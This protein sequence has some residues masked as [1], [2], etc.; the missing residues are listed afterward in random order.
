MQNTFQT[1]IQFYDQL[2]DV[3]IE[4]PVRVSY[5]YEAEWP[6]TEYDPGE[7]EIFEIVSI[8]DMNTHQELSDSDIDFVV[9]CEEIEEEIRSF[10]ANEY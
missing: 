2:L 5:V 1:V 9:V 10:F 4:T 7:A 8:V 6:A 3:E